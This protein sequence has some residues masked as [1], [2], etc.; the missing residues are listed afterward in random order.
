MCGFHLYRVTIVW[1]W[2][3]YHTRTE[4]PLNG[5][6]SIA[7]VSSAAHIKSNIIREI[8]IERSGGRESDTSFDLINYVY[9][10]WYIG[11][12]TLCI[13]F[14]KWCTLGS[15]WNKFYSSFVCPLWFFEL[16]AMMVDKKCQTRSGTVKKNIFKSDPNQSS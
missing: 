2:L 11:I 13:I 15:L 3:I 12:I 4:L 9:D 5:R 16:L 10:A 6:F 7:I 14:K 1:P 8:Q